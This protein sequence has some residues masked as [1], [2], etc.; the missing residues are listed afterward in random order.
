MGFCEVNDGFWRIIAY[1][2]GICVVS[3]RVYVHNAISLNIF[4][5]KCQFNATVN[6]ALSAFSKRSKVITKNDTSGNTAI[7]STC[8][9]HSAV[10]P[11][12]ATKKSIHNLLHDKQ[13]HFISTIIDQETKCKISLKKAN[14]YSA[15]SP[16][17]ISIETHFVHRIPNIT[18]SC[19]SVRISYGH[20]TLSPYVFLCF[21]FLQNCQPFV[22]RGVI[23]IRISV[24]RPTSVHT[25]NIPCLR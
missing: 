11:S 17:K 22:S 1:L 24:Q 5:R 10:Q 19:Y 7:H 3:L 16:R 6:R 13:L 15:F 14:K 18:L 2:V 4:I 8:P 9:N 20:L 21:V 25:T 12:I 23:L